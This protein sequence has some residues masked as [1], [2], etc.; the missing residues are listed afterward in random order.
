MNRWLRL[1]EGTI[2]LRRL[3]KG[4]QSVYLSFPVS[5]CFRRARLSKNYFTEE[6]ALLLGENQD[7]S[8]RRG[9]RNVWDLVVRRRLLKWL[10]QYTVD[11][12][13]GCFRALCPPY[14]TAGA[15]VAP[16]KFWIFSMLCTTSAITSGGKALC[17]LTSSGAAGASLGWPDYLYASFRSSIDRTNTI[18][19]DLSRA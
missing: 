14:A 3:V 13:G 7:L 15:N 1:C 16:K 2:C 17:H 6:G 8:V 5:F 10:P 11:S 4:C 9:S 18:R 19:S 12:L